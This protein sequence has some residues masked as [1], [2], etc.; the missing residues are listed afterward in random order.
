MEKIRQSL[1]W[2]L[3]CSLDKCI[4]EL[5]GPS[6]ITITKPDGRTYTMAVYETG[7][8]EPIGKQKSKK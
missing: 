3:D 7:A 8:G 4:I 6:A 5:N 2:F 1:E